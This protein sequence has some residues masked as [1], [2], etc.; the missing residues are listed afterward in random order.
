MVELGL[1]FM[2]MIDGTDCV[3]YYSA[4]ECNIFDIPVEKMSDPDRP[5]QTSW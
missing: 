1:I 5:S 3:L 4:F 2:M